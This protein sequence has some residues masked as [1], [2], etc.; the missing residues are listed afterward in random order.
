MK[1]K[2]LTEGVIKPFGHLL[3]TDWRLLFGDDFTAEFSTKNKGF[4]M[5]VIVKRANAPPLTTNAC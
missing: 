3:V 2:T 4:N 1:K 5:H